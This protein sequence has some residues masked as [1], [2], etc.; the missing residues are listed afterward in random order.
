M[1]S[2]LPPGLFVVNQNVSTLSDGTYKV[3]ATHGFW[4]KLVHVSGPANLEGWINTS[5]VNVVWK[6]NN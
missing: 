2:P 3:E 5:A 4:V 1:Q 6:K